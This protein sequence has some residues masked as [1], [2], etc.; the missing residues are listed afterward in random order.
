MNPGNRDYVGGREYRE[1]ALHFTVER[2]RRRLVL[3]DTT[4]PTRRRCE[5]NRLR[6]VAWKS[7]VDDG[8]GGY[9][10]VDKEVVEPEPCRSWPDETT[11]AGIMATRRERRCLADTDPEA[12]LGRK[13]PAAWGCVYEQEKKSRSPRNGIEGVCW[14]ALVPL[15]LGVSVYFA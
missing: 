14:L 5:A 12:F 13:A 11:A 8:I 9:R 7:P 4:L 3:R 10:C 15:M 2:G 6:S 1:T